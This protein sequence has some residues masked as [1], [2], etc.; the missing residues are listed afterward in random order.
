MEGILWIIDKVLEQ[1]DENNDSI[2][3]FENKFRAKIESATSTEDWIKLF[4]QFFQSI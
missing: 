2:R 1:L 4:K 3:E